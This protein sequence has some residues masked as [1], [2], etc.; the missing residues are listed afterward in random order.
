MEELKSEGKCF[1]CN[2]VFSGSGIS[3]HLKSHLQNLE[4]EKKSRKKSFHVKVTGERFYFL[5]LLIN[6]DTTLQELDYYLKDIW[7]ECCGHLSSFE[8]KGAKK[9]QDWLFFNE[10]EFGIDMRTKIGGL[11][12]KG[13]KL[14]YEYDFGST[15]YL[16]ISVI[17]EYFVQDKSEILLLSRN[18]PLKILCDSCKKNPAK[19]MC[20][21]WHDDETMFCDSCKDLHAKNCSDFQEYSEA[22][23]VNSPRLGVCA[24]DGGVIDTERDG[25]WQ[26]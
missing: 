10:E 5:H 19:V 18:E 24:Y 9:T 6:Q 13:L 20:T 26:K 8:I 22:N 25:I 15:T 14:D 12:K 16:E 23:I 2:K 1:Y 4:K 11:L 3:R 21:L 7:L 17:N